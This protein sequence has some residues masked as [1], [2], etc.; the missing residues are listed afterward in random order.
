MSICQLLVTRKLLNRTERLKSNNPTFIKGT[1]GMNVGTLPI[2]PQA[3]LRK[4]NRTSAGS[5]YM[6]GCDSSAMTTTIRET[7]MSTCGSSLYFLMEKH[8]E[9]KQFKLLMVFFL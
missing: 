8:F 4:C 3:S 5:L 6:T 9:M 2:E 1:K 7:P